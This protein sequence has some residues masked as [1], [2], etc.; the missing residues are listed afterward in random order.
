MTGLVDQ[1]G[2]PLKASPRPNVRATYDLAQTTVHNKKH[3]ANSDAM[4]ARAAMNPAVRELVRRRSRYEFDNNS[5]YCGILRTAANHVVG[6]GPTLQVL[7]KNTVANERL[8]RAWRKFSRQIR[9]GEL[10]RMIFETY[11]KDGEVFAMRRD[12]WSRQP[13]GLDVVTIEAEQVAAPWIGSHIGDPLVDDGI[14]IDDKNNAVEYYVYDHH[15]NEV[16]FVPTLKGDWVP[17][18]EIIHLYRSERPGQ[19]RGIPRATCALNT[20]PIMRRQ[21]MAT[22]LAAETSASLATFMKSTGPTVTA[23]KS[24]RDFAQIELAYNMLTTL[25]EGW[26][27]A[28][29]DPK[30]PGP[31]YEMFQRQALTSFCRC[32]N[33]HYGL[34][35]GTSRDSNF[36]S[37]KGDRTD[38][39]EPEVKTEQQ[40]MELCVVEKVFGWFLDEAAIYAEDLL[41]GLPPIAELEWKWQWPALPN[42]DELDAAIAAEKRLQSGQSSPS[43]EMAIKGQDYN[44]TVTKM[45]A[46]YGVPV[47]SV[48]QAVFQKTFGLAQ[49][50]ASPPAA[51]PAPNAPGAPAAQAEAGPAS[52]FKEDGQRVYSNT[53]K[54][55]ESILQRVVAGEITEGRALLDMEGIGMP[56]ARAM[57]YLETIRVREDAE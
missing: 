10:L 47:E 27:I 31:H 35:A 2:Q 57:R 54:R 20:L 14:R 49:M 40:R 39:W 44:T 51:M 34:A 45:A 19:V 7:S 25:P 13:V 42:I 4:A 16:A 30:H 33:M 1:Y 24:P 23:A 8:E 41:A 15:P 48:K 5:W 56:E 36:S 29:L 26:D 53:Q 28:Q 12:R 17:E 46:D 3:W 21:E 32:T 22:L 52:E 43:D 11:W 18:T 55:L 38:V 9:F 50:P 37:N 6:C